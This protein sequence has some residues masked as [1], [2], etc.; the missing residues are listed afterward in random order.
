MISIVQNGDEVFDSEILQIIDMKAW[1]HMHVLL[2][3]HNYYM[4]R[5]VACMKEYQMTI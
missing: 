3:N 1:L 4:F 5:L 2:R